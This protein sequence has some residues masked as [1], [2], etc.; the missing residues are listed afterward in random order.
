MK[1]APFIIV[2]IIVVCGFSAAFSSSLFFKHGNDAVFAASGDGPMWLAN[3]PLVTSS[4]A[5][6]GS[7]GLIFKHSGNGKLW[8]TS[9]NKVNTGGGE[10]QMPG[11]IPSGSLNLAFGVNAMTTIADDQIYQAAPPG[12]QTLTLT[13]EDYYMESIAKEN[14]QTHT[15]LTQY[16]DFGDGRID[17]TEAEEKKL[18]Y[19]KDHLGSTREVISEEGTPVERVIYDAYGLMT[20]E[21]ILAGIEPNAKDKFTGKE[22]DKEGAY[23]ESGIQGILLNYIGMRYYDPDVGIW[24]ETDAAGEF[25]NSYSYSGGNPINFVDPNG[26]STCRDDVTGQVTEVR[27]DGDLTVYNWNQ[28]S[29]DDVPVGKTEFWNEFKTGDFIKLQDVTYLMH[30]HQSLYVNEK[31]AVSLAVSSFPGGVLDVKQELGPTTGYIYKG[32]M[33]TGESIGNRLAGEDAA[34]LNIPLGATKVAAG[35]LHLGTNFGNWKDVTWKYWGETEYTG[36]QIQSG[37]QSVNR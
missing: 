19:L 37:Y 11:T 30:L 15:P 28:S 5:P 36:R 8:T 18:F 29:A 35:L 33:M 32:Y 22:F 16:W 3:P 25:W 27:N 26:L 9:D 24:L 34:L 6:V 4:S 23:S 1:H 17:Y 31:D 20:D 12:G 21:T 13:K 7:H 2:G 14:D 10:A